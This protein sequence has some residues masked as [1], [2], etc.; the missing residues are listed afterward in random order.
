MLGVVPFVEFMLVLGRGI[1]PDQHEGWGLGWRR[2]LA[3]KQ[4]LALVS[5][6]AFAELCGAFG[7][8]RPV[9]AAN[10]EVGRAMQHADIVEII[11][12]DRDL[13][14]VRAD[15]AVRVQ[16]ARHP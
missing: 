16:K 12:R 2:P 7:P 4:L 13:W 3:G 15:P 1:H 9:L 5:Q 6:Y 10:R 11:G 14:V 8:R